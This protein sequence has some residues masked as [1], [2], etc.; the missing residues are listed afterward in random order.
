QDN[1]SPVDL[2]EVNEAV[3]GLLREFA[4]T[5]GPGDDE[6]LV[7]SV[8]KRVSGESMPESTSAGATVG[9]PE[10]D[11]PWLFGRQFWK[12]TAAIV[13]V[14]AVGVGGN[15]W[16]I[17]QAQADPTEVML[18][19]RPRFAP[20]DDAT[21]RVLV[22]HGRSH[23]PLANA[24]V[25]VVLSGKDSSQHVATVKTDDDGIVD[26]SAEL[27]QELAEGSYQFNVSV[28]AS[29]GEA[30]A[31]QKITVAR[32]YRTMV[33]TDKP[34]YQP[35]QT[36]HMRA[37]SLNVDSMTPA[38]QR[39][40]EFVVRD[41]KGNKVFAARPET[42]DFG[43]AASDFK[44][45]DQ[46][47][48]GDYQIAV[49][50][51]D[52]T[53]ER[54][55]KVQ[56]YVLPKFRVALK[57]NRTYYAP[58]DDVTLTLN[59]DYTF[60]KPTAGADV[61]IEVADQVAGR[62]VF[63]TVTGKTNAEGLFEANFQLKDRLVGTEANGGDAEVFF[64][65]SVTDKTGETNTKS[66]SRIVAKSPLRIE[67]F[68][69]SGELVPGVENTLYIMTAFPDGTPVQTTVTTHAGTEVTT[70][71]VGIGKVKLT[72]KRRDLK[73]TL[74][75]RV[76]ATGVTGSAVKNLRMGSATD[77]VLL[78]TDRAI[79]K[80]GQTAKLTVFSGTPA[81][82]AFVDVIRNGRSLATTAIDLANN[83]G[84]YSLDLPADVL[85]TVQVQAYCVQPSGRIARDTKV[86]QVRRVDELKVT[87]TLDAETYKPAEQAMVNFLVQSKNG[88]P[89]E[90][91]LSL[92]IVDEAVFA[93][94]DSRP[95]LEEMY[96]LVQEELL[97]PR[98]QFIT[99]PGGEFTRGG[100]LEEDQVAEA[101][102]VRFSAAEATDADAPVA[103]GGEALRAR[104]RTID[105]SQRE[106]K[107]SLIRLLSN[108][109]FAVFAILAGIF[110]IYSITRL[111]YRARDVGESVASVF[112]SE[113]RLLYWMSV[114]A[115]AAIPTAVYVLEASGTNNGV[116]IA[117]ALGIVCCVGL[118]LIVGP[119]VRIRR[120]PRIL[121]L[122]PLLRRVIWIVP[123]LYVAMVLLGFGQALAERIDSGAI[124]HADQS[125][126][127]VCGATF[128]FCLGFVGFL[129]NVLIQ[130]QTW[131]AKLVSLCLHQSVPLVLF[132]G[133]ALSIPSVQQASRDAGFDVNLTGGTME[134]FMVDSMAP[135]GPV[136]G[137]DYNFAIDSVLA[138]GG[139]TQPEPRVR[140]FF[141]ETLL[142]QPQLLT[143]ASGKAQ[144]SVPLADS[145]TTWRL[146]GSA[147]DVTGRMGS[148]QDGIR[149]FQ[150]FF[151][152]IQM[153]V[154]LTQNDEISIP[155]SIFNYL[156]E[157]QTIVLE[158]SEGDW[159]EFVD[160]EPSKSVEAAANEVL[161][162][163][164]RIRVLKPGR[165]AMTIKAKGNVLADAVERTVR[166]EPDGDRQELVANAKLVGEANEVLNI[167]ANAIEGGNDLFVKIYPGGFSQVVEGM[168]SIFRMPHGCF[169]QT[170][171]TTYPNVLVLT[172]L[173]EPGQSNPS[174]EMKALG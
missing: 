66:L 138:D 119:I 104:Q 109:P 143:D 51:G 1:D 126:L 37:L 12:L 59:A 82:R 31:T 87:A 112:R 149:V 72:P 154:K 159:F 24:E 45:A 54:T 117:L 139:K 95:G 131:F 165:H 34:L 75:A 171:S 70:N 22:R 89:V 58:G 62:S 28:T 20:G 123:A 111:G 4:R 114:V 142:W 105:E 73:L 41:G 64:L 78:R 160:D 25:S 77:S 116:L 86:I 68:P 74:T 92:A 19:T 121:E 162:S 127:L 39:A 67:V 91:A 42:S 96:F 13:L 118:S 50:V 52:T 173:R 14:F 53:S 30:A 137:M 97:K 40:V 161:R 166:V 8:L 11:W 124:R 46:V 32:T 135:G 136:L 106:N 147:V 167:P 16:F 17:S 2:S 98:Y 63:Q 57:S 80:Q 163:S 168:D 83:K 5:G 81:K 128:F 107:R 55:V 115:V 103:V 43:I 133:L 100:E 130:R 21:L 49:T 101:Q 108:T 7:Q 172:Y 174:I 84:Q 79:Y 144:L 6:V 148:F 61:R 156:N 150:D 33:S 71:E 153:P 132:G 145:I 23:Q 47:N 94:N 38:K 122:A 140:R 18:F 44:L 157:P 93:L 76:E 9:R 125:R 26:I 158:A 10:R 69:E 29:T 3:D 88:D 36:I 113:M 60:G 90:A 99:R 48:E 120:L 151:V 134:A 152:D 129:R 164:F 35:G 169:E 85:G 146:A 65:A 141:P 102:V 110:A 15:A 155:I 56:H 27:D 170:S